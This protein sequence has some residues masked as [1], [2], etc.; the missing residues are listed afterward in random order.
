MAANLTVLDKPTADETLRA[1][2]V[3]SMQEISAL[4]EQGEIHA[5][6]AIVI[7]ADGSFRVIKDGEL[8][9]INTVDY[10]AQAQHD[11]LAY[12]SDDE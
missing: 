1:R 8:R 2:M 6:V 10:L 3:E 7:R 4:C 5:F 12:E 9:R 11:L